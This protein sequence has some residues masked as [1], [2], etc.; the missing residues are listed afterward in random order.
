MDTTAKPITTRVLTPYYDSLPGGKKGCFFYIAEHDCVCLL[1][2]PYRKDDIEGSYPAV[3]QSEIAAAANPDCQ[4]AWGYTAYLIAVMKTTAIVPSSDIADQYWTDYVN[5]MPEDEMPSVGEEIGNWYR[6]LQNISPYIGDGYAVFW[7]HNV[8]YIGEVIKHLFVRMFPEQIDLDT[9]FSLFSQRIVLIG[10]NTPLVATLVEPD[11]KHPCLQMLFPQLVLTKDGNPAICLEAAH[12]NVWAAFGFVSLLISN[13]LKA[14]YYAF[15]RNMNF[16]DM[17][18]LKKMSEALVSDHR[19]EY[20]SPVINLQALRFDFPFSYTDF[21]EEYLD[22]VVPVVRDCAAQDPTFPMELSEDDN[23]YSY[24]LHSEK[25]A[26]QVFMTNQLHASFTR[27][28]QNAIETYFRRYLQYLEKQYGAS[29]ELMNRINM[30]EYGHIEPLQISLTTHMKIT[31]KDGNDVSLER[32]RMSGWDLPKQERTTAPRPESAPD[33]VVSI[34]SSDEILARIRDWAAS[35]SKTKDK[36]MALRAAIDA[37]VIRRPS[38]SEFR[39]AFPEIEVPKSSLSDYTNPNKCPYFD[40]AYTA[41]VEDF[42]Q[43]K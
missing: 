1:D 25:T 32:A 8:Y 23:I 5:T 34:A 13:A 11:S 40:S 18:L 2:T 16:H 20:L 6:S 3:H 43:Y 39:A 12:K 29:E 42:K 9:I 37:G 17:S 4:L 36:L 28:Q 41:L 26:Y 33:F 19:I 10:Q 22:T 24:I 21:F 14:A 38:E 35:K 31:D 7:D 27:Q 15:W 30:Q